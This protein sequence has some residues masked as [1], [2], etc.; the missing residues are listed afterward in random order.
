[1]NEPQNKIQL[2]ALYIKEKVAYDMYKSSKSEK[3]K[4]YY[5]NELNN[6]RQEI[7]DIDISI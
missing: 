3:E 1:M 5:K 4:K 7:D 2:E 6:I